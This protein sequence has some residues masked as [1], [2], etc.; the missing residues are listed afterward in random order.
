MRSKIGQIC[1]TG[2]ITVTNKIHIDKP[3]GI[4]ADEIA[5]VEFIQKTHA[6]AEQCD[7]TAR[8]ALNKQGYDAVR[9]WF[10]LHS[11]IA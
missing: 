2:C 3:C 8:V 10:S 6:A 7:G 5:G 11:G 9:K 1:A 4:A